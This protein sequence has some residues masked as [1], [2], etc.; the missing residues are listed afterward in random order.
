VINGHLH[1][2]LKNITCG[3]TTWLNPG[4][5]ARVQR[6]DA[7]REARPAAMRL[8]VQSKK[9]WKTAH[10]EIPHEPFDQVFYE[11]G[12]QDDNISYGESA[13]IKGLETLRTLRT[14]TGSG[15]MSFLQKNISQF[16]PHVSGEILSLARE[17]CRDE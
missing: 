3:A 17:V 4:N 16:P 13:F 12:P 1:R 15:L 9:V 2:P 6:A 14:A 7:I 5:I 10:V 11:L 8:D